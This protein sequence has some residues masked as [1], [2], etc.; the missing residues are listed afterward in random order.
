MLRNRATEATRACIPIYQ[1]ITL[2]LL[3]SPC[4][5]LNPDLSGRGDTGGV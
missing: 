5:F 2:P 4:L 1:G 3:L